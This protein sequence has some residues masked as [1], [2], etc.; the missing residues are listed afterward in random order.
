MIEPH[1]G[2]LVDKVVGDKYADQLRNEV[3][4]GPRIDLNVSQYQDAI[5]IATGRFSPI[6]GYLTQNDFLKVVHDMTLE[7]G[8]TWPL[9]ITLDVDSTVAEDLTPGEKALLR[10]PAEEPIGVIDV[11]EVYKHNKDDTVEYV[12]GTADQDHPGVANYLNQEDFLV[13]GPIYLFDE[14]RY[15]SRDL[16]PAESRVLFSHRDWETVAGFQTRNAPHRAHEYIQKSALEQTDGLLIQPKLGDK[17]VDDYRDDTILGA[18]ETLIEEYYREGMVALSVFPS[19][20]RYAGPREAIFDAIVRKNQGCT[21]FVVGRDHAGVGD[22]Y[23]EF[24][25]Q[26]IFGDIADIGIEPL[27]YDYSFYCHSC[28][29]MTSEKICPHGSEE[30]VHPS[31]SRIRS[32]IGEGKQPS[33][34]MM[35]PEVASYVMDADEPFVTEDAPVGGVQ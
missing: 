35:R 10:S 18:Y 14:H 16:L 22:Y 3:G 30:Q 29:G 23:H 1:G 27:F 17:K 34:K 12:F 19:Q 15:N 8:V 20:M 2:R 21:H 9:P 33:A 13:G 31:G 5:N 6:D 4:R 26:R 25:A 24:G 28:D 32:L 11:E 7:N